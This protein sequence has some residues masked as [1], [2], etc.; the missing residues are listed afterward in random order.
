MRTIG[1][2]GGMSWESTAVYYRLINEEVRSRLGGLHSAKVVLHSFDF[3]QITALQRQGNWQCA[4]VLL[5]ET[6]QALERAGAEVAAICTNTM[7]KTADAVQEGIHIP[8]LHIADCTAAAINA[9]NLDT[10]GLLGTRYTMEQDFLRCRL[11]KSG[12]LRVIAPEETERNTVHSIIF[13]ELC[14]GKVASSSRENLQQVVA[15][16][17]ANGAQGVILGCTELMLLLSQEQ[18]ALPLFDTTALHAQALVDFAL[19]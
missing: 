11:A 10:V 13:D 5:T 1:L 16:L 6:A 14:Q 17:A 7:H 18:C 3:A 19:A 9:A 4:S 8:L 12:H 15:H 2:I